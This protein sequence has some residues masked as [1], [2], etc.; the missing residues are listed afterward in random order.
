MKRL[1]LNLDELSR[2]LEMLDAEYLRGLKGGYGEYGGYN[3]WEELWEAMQHG[4]Q[5]PEGT[6]YPGGDPTDGSYGNYNGYGGYSGY[7]NYGGGWQGWFPGWGYGGDYGG[8]NYPSGYGGYSSGYMTYYDGKY[9]FN[10]P[11]SS[12]KDI[13]I[14]FGETGNGYSPIDAMKQMLASL[15]LAASHADASAAIMN[16]S[17]KGFNI[18]SSSFGVV[19]IVTNGIE[20]WEEPN[21]EDA[22]QILLGAGLI[23]FGSNP[24]IIIVGGG[25]LFGWELIEALQGR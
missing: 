10:L 1:K 25:V 22:S 2:E 24:A 6:Y 12:D 4:Y 14:D 23:F 20:F 17:T 5:P 13:N 18:A 16:L 11:I 21:W 7:G 3:S 9:H 8:Y 19:D 15:G